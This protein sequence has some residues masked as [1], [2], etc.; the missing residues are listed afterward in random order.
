MQDS[1]CSIN[2]GDTLPVVGGPADGTT[3]KVEWLFPFLESPATI[4]RFD[5]HY[6]VL[7]KKKRAYIYQGKVAKRAK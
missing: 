3:H 2:N 5:E 6:Y 1:Q 4:L 7:D